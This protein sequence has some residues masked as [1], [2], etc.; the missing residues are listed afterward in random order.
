[1]QWHEQVVRSTIWSISRPNYL[2][3]GSKLYFGHSWHDFLQDHPV[4]RACCA[5]SFV[6]NNRTSLNNK[7]SKM[8][9]LRQIAFDG[10]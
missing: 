1:M 4:A 3:K 8:A 6:P 9:A 2:K 5:H 10:K 7:G